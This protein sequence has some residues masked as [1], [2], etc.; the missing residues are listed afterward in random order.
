[1]AVFDGGRRGLFADSRKA[2]Q[3]NLRVGVSHWNS[4][5]GDEVREEQRDQFEGCA[6]V[7]WFP[8]RWT[9]STTKHIFHYS[10]EQSTIDNMVPY[11]MLALRS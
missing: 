3:V 5:A 6:Q 8:Y 9:T 7:E 11:I 4:S 10:E 2:H 1:M